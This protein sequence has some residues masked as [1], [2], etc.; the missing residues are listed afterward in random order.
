VALLICVVDDDE[1]SR[2]A[3]SGLLRSMG[4]DVVD[5]ACAAD[6]LASDELGRTGFLFADQRMPGMGGLE[7]HQR[8][9][10]S[11]MALPTA[12]VT[13]YPTEAGREQALRAGIRFFLAK[14]VSP[15]DLAACLRP[16]GDP[17][18]R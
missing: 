15:Q 14:P 9:V 11:G 8:L 17:L 12:I 5:F 18:A 16:P 3:I 7:L 2:A 6:F 10:A 13:A 1:A 4:H